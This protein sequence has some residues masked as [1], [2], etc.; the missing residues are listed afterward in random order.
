M[1]TQTATDNGQTVTPEVLSQKAASLPA[2]TPGFK[3]ETNEQYE[4]IGE[5]IVLAKAGV[6]EAESYFKPIKRKIDETKAEALSQEKRAKKP[7][8][9]FLSVATP[10][11]V[12][13]IEEQER[14]RLELQ[15]KLEEEQRR[16]EEEARLAE[17][18]NL[19]ERGETELAEQVLSEPQPLPPP[20]VESFT[21]KVAGLSTRKEWDFQITD[22][23]KI[24]R[25]F[26]MADEVKI[27][28][29]VRALGS[30][31]AELIGGIRVFERTGLAGRSR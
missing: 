9:D 6:R 16:I 24:K 15:R 27:R 10:A 19:E 1:E 29:T 3:I 21:P 7:F 11:T 2:V 5:Y 22:A 23:G 14:K 12:A 13:W 4:Q 26:L 18:V 8:E 31:S 20:V 25:E 28:K 30:K 17:A